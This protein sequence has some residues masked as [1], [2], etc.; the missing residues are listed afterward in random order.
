M[1]APERRIHDSRP[2]WRAARTLARQGRRFPVVLLL[3]LLFPCISRA[4]QQAPETYDPYHAQKNVDV[5][6][7]YLKKGRYAAAISRFKQALRDQPDNTD[8]LLHLGEAYEKKGEPADAIKSYREY[9]RLLPEAKNAPKI[10]ERIEKL[11]RH[12][13][14]RGSQPARPRPSG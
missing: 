12:E 3:V 13:P 8:A 1:R 6:I 9:L 11:S 14:K 7:F 4:Q 5:G 10:R 2:V